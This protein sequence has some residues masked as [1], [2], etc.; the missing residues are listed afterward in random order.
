[1]GSMMREVFSAE[2]I[3]V[4][5]QKIMTAH[6]N[7]GSHLSHGRSIVSRDSL[8][9]ISASLIYD[10]FS[11]IPVLNV[12]SDQGTRGGFLPSRTRLA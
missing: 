9:T 4:E 5:K 1:M 8:A 12:R 11:P 3:E 6:S 10:F 7:T 2:K